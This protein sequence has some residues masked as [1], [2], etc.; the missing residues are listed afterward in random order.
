VEIQRGIRSG[1]HAF[2]GVVISSGGDIGASFFFDLDV[3]Q[4][5][6]AD[7][8][9]GRWYAMDDHQ[10]RKLQPQPHAMRREMREGKAEAGCDCGESRLAT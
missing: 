1:S 8:N 3:T 10:L 6:S 4:R 9:E 5:R 7:A 2:I